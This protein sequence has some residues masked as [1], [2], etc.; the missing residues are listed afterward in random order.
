MTGVDTL[1]TPIALPSGDTIG[2]LGFYT[3]TSTPDARDLRAVRRDVA[4]AVA[5]YGTVI[6]TMHLGA[7]G[8]P[9]QRTQNANERF[10][11]TDRGNPVGF[12]DAAFSGGATLVDW[13]RA[14]RAAR[15]GMARRR[16]WCSIRSATC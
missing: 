4:R 9:A 10:L 7:E 6:V 13:A 11:D 8:P 15:G 16:S 1:A 3:D 14:A 2:V 12:A 5:R